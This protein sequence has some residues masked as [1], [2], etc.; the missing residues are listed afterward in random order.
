MYPYFFFSQKLTIWYYWLYYKYSYDINSCIIDNTVYVH[1]TGQTSLAQIYYILFYVSDAW[2][3]YLQ[4]LLQM[5]SDFCNG[6]D[7]EDT[8]TRQCSINIY[9]EL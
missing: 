2:K 8:E 3:T 6:E 5:L 1:D 4:L 7:W 9:K